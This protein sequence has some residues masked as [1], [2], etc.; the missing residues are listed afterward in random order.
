MPI[1]VRNRTG[2]RNE[3]KIDARNVRRYWQEA[4]LEDA[5]DGRRAGWASDG[6]RLA[7]SI[8]ERPVRRRKTSS[9]ED[10]R[11]STVSGFR[12]RWWTATAAASPS[13]AYSRTRSGRCSTRW[14]MPVELA[15]ERLGDPGREAQLGH[16]ACRVALDELARAALGDDLRLVHDDQPVA[17]L[18]GLVHV[19]RR[20]DQR[21]AALLEPVEAIPQEVAGLRVEPGRR[22]VEQQDR[23]SR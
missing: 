5:T 2:E 3:V 7:Y 6:H 13:S 23:R 12:P 11:T 19:V 1:A 14:A 22:L 16:L 17:Q 21:H 10:R 20:Q 8:S 15:V 4:V 18:L 9:S